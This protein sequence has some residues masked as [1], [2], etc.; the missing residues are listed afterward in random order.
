MSELSFYHTS[1]LL[2]ETVEALRIKADGLYVDGTLGGGGHSSKILESLGPEACLLGLDKD[3]DALSYAG[4]RLD[5]VGTK[6]HIKLVQSDYADFPKVLEDLHLGPVDGFLLDLGVSSWQLD[7]GERGFSYRNDG[8]L[9]MRM[10]RSHGESVKEFLARTDQ[11]TLSQIIRDFGEERFHDRIARAILAYRDESGPIETT[12]QLADIVVRAM[13][14]SSRREKGHPAKRTFQALRIY[15]NDEL[16]A[17][18][19]FL[20]E[21]L[22]YL[23]PGGVLAIISFHSLEDRMVKQA[24]RLWE[25][26][27]Q[28]PPNL[29]CT[30]GQTPWGK[31]IP[32]GGIVPSAE[33][34]AEN[35]RAK[36]ARLR[37]FVRNEDRKE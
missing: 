27:C 22:T 33:E 2:E 32:R 7:Q 11:K 4:R 16:G 25:N 14:A 13:P 37:V 24:Y 36:S 15:I 21:I 20:D 10:D 17:L 26:P 23:K 30:C 29:P 28:C 19:T 5:Q 3:Q 31:E 8:P 34:M 1:I 6:A 12:G 18:R 35:P 9:D